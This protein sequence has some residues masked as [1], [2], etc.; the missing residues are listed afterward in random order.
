MTARSD[1][2]FRSMT[3]LPVMSGMAF[4]AVLLAGAF[5]AL[6]PVSLQTAVAASGTN[7]G[8]TLMAQD[9]DDDRIRLNDVPQLVVRGTA[10]LDK[11]ADQVLLSAGVETTG[12]D[13]RAALA[14]N[15]QQ[16]NRVVEAI[17]AAG[18]T[19]DDY[20]TGRF[21][22]RP[23]YARRPR[24]APDDWQPRIVGYVVSNSLSI[25]TGKMELVG[26]LIA[27][28]NDAGANN[29]AIDGFGLAEPEQ[30]RDE[31]IGAA[32]RQAISEARVAATAAGLELVRI[33]RLEVD[34][35][36]SSGGGRPQA[37]MMRSSAMAD[38][39]PPIEGGDVEI[40][41]GVRIVYEVRGN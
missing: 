35:A 33:I 38:S 8:T 16:M 10:S 6:R 29:V 23:E 25:A 26:E 18:L 3:T 20:K 11:A 4:G 7:A 13:A 21:R 14:D 2:I 12:E 36:P 28:C 41:A 32:T 15:S 24:N 27:A 22:I 19:K 17:K 5:A 39:A 30:Y 31:A 40:T 37:R 34:P 1:S 9:E